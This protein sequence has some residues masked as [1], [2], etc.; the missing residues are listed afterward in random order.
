MSPS[1][2]GWKNAGDADCQ[3]RPSG[4]SEQ[5]E[6]E[7]PH[8]GALSGIGGMAVKRGQRDALRQQSTPGLATPGV[9]RS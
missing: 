7:G 4:W 9:P 5:R 1:E 3:K 8:A 2:K 6:S